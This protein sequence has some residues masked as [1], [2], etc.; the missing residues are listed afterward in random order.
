MWWRAR[1]E[2][3][4]QAVKLRKLGSSDLWWICD[5][6]VLHDGR[7][8]ATYPEFWLRHK[9]AFPDPSETIEHWSCYKPLDDAPELFLEFA[10]LSEAPDF[11]EAVLTFSRKYGVPGRESA[12]GAEYPHV[13]ELAGRAKDSES[14]LR[15]LRM[16]E[17][18]INRD[19]VRADL[20]LREHY[21]AYDL[22]SEEELAE[23]SK[24]DPAREALECVTVEVEM[25]VQRLCLPYLGI[26]EAV[27]PP[28]VDPTKV[29]A[30]WL[31]NNLLG[32]AY[33]QMYWLIA[34]ANELRRC[35]YCGRLISLARHRSRKR[36]S[37]NDKKF[38]DEAC[39]QSNHRSKKRA[40]NAP[41]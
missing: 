17:A 37:R 29:E 41:S 18:V 3:V 35:E 14:A 40:H 2:D 36:K 15:I 33:L 9:G 4:R 12:S 1:G 25:T 30:G 32:A 16:Y 8:V 21:A 6:Y 7:V 19:P 23:W 11:D 24:W 26:D 34:S 39:R 13:T 27:K 20:L 5:D 10:R 31:F 22:P 28:E 38:C